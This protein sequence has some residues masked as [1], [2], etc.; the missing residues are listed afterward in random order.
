MFLSSDIVANVLYIQVL[1]LP[2]T[3]K[4]AL[5]LEGALLLGSLSQRQINGLNVFFDLS[6]GNV[7]MRE[8]SDA[9]P[10]L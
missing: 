2:L 1:E 4:I 6:F 7:W 5:L 10:L 9:L 3:V 8:S